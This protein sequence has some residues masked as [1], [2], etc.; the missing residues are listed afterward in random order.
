MKKFSFFLIYFT[1]LFGP[2]VVAKESAL[3]SPERAIQTQNIPLGIERDLPADARIALDIKPQVV[4]QS[5]RAA[6]FVLPHLESIS[7]PIVYPKLAVRRGWEGETVVAA[8]VLA[9][10]AVGRRHVAKSSGHEILDQTALES[11]ENWKFQPALKNGRPVISH[12]EIPITFR[13]KDEG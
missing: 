12:L 13:L 9:N 4:I 10:G 6:L 8:E 1:V 7:E 2:A 11:A 5:N 3:L